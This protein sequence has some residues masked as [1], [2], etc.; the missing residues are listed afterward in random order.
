VRELAGAA[1]GVAC[2]LL[3]APYLAQLTRSVPDGAD[4]RWWRG[5]RV[6]ARRRLVTGL[7]A[8]L[9]GALAGLAAGWSALLPALIALALCAAP[10]VVIDL[11]LHRL[12]D[13]LV[14]AAA[15]LAAALLALAAFVRGDWSAY[16]RALAAAAA[17]LAALFV[18]ALISPSSFGLGDVKLGAVL[19]AYLGW[20]GWRYVYWG[21]A[22]GFVLGAVVALGLIATRRATMKT[23]LAFG[24]MLVLGTLLTLLT[25]Q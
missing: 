3:A 15:I 12:P 8:V 21:I 6:G 17:V 23:A 25:T 24:P 5:Q 9:L 22:V 19:G 20:F 7:V 11:Q 1:V 14:L 2:C 18:L 13:R 4:R 10:L 16:L